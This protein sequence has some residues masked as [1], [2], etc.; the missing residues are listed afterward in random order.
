MPVYEVKLSG[1]ERI[2]E[3]TMAFRFEKPAGFAFEPGQAIAV[4]LLD[5]PA[6]EAQRRR[7]FSLVSAPF[8]S[9]LEIA[10]RMRDSAFKR[11]LLE[12]PA[13]AGVRLEG[14][15]GTLTL[16]DA[17]LPAVL[18]AG[19][20]GITPFMS[21]LRQAA[22]DARPQRLLLAYSNRRPEDAAYLD[23]LR[24]LER[25]NANFRLLATMTDLRG[26]SR[27]WNGETGYIGAGMLK[28][29]AGDLAA[30]IYYVVG[31]PAMVE[32]MQAMLQKAGVAA[33]RIRTEEFYGY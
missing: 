9:A 2:A 12:L 24:A 20:I 21:M 5:P 11:A 26:S 4:E 7:T 33:D 28:R 23:E 19:G 15:F 31:P 25:R 13:G 32:A 8:E 18:L 17:T 1:R 6:D 3:G 22:H 29:F 10:T 30:A 14:P 27:A 16:G